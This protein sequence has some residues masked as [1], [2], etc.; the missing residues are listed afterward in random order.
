V[1]LR[2]SFSAAEKTKEEDKTTTVVVSDIIRFIIVILT[3]I[4]YET[5]KSLFPWYRFWSHL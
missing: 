4:G 3:S 1:F 5:Q 2:Q